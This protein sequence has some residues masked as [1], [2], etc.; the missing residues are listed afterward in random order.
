MP[1]SYAVVNGK[2]VAYG[3]ATTLVQGRSAAVH[4]PPPPIGGE[5]AA[6]RRL[7]R[8]LTDCRWVH[9]GGDGRLNPYWAAR[10]LARGWDDFRAEF[11]RDMQTLARVDPMVAGRV[12]A[13]AFARPCWLA[14]DMR[15]R[16]WF[17]EVAPFGAAY[18]PRLVCE[19]YEKHF[20]DDRKGPVPMGRET[21]RITTEDSARWGGWR[22]SGDVREGTFHEVMADLDV[23]E[24]RLNEIHN[25]FDETA[26]VVDGE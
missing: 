16:G 17:R 19:V 18:S 24:S 13:A 14:L 2:P 20:V 6:M 15:L 5:A 22:S 11:V 9:P 10:Q 23:P 26:K 3:K 4:I 25:E 12:D 8:F 1:E 7:L 21:F